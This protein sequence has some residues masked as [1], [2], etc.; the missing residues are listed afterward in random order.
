MYKKYYLPTSD[1]KN[2]NVI[3][4]GRNCFDRTIK[5]NLR[6]YGNFWKI[7]TGQC[8]DYTIGCLLDLFYFEKYYKLQ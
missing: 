7:R 1:I 3:T 5:N 8:D 4:D 2:Y 6:T